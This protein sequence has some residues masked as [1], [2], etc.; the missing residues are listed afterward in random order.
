MPSADA[1]TPEPQGP[2]PGSFAADLLRAKKLTPT[3]V[4]VAYDPMTGLALN[5]S[6][7]PP[8][9][10]S[11]HDATIDK[12]AAEFGVDPSF[13]RAIIS[14]GERS[15]VRATS[16][17]GAQ[18]LMQLMPLIQKTY[19]VTDPMDPD[20]N[21]K[22]GVRHLRVLL[23]K[24]EGDETKTAAAYNAGEPAVNKA[25][26]IP[27]ITETQEYVGRVMQ[28]R[29]GP[30]LDRGSTPGQPAPLPQTP[31][32]RPIPS[33][34]APTAS[35]LRDETLRGAAD[36]VSDVVEAGMR[37]GSPLV[38]LGLATAPWATGIAMGLAT[39]ADAA[40]EEFGTRQGWSPE[41]VRLA[42]NAAVIA[43]LG[44]GAKRIAK[45]V[46]KG[47]SAME[48]SAWENGK[49]LGDIITKNAA[50]RDAA[51][52]KTIEQRT[53][54]DLNRPTGAPEP[55]QPP[56]PAQ[57]PVEPPAA[58]WPS[59]K[60]PA[61]PAPPGSF[62]ADL[63]R[64]REGLV[65]PPVSIARV[66]SLEVLNTDLTDAMNHYARQA[67][68]FEAGSAAKGTG[69]TY[70]LHR[71]LREA[72]GQKNWEDMTPLE[73][74][75]EFLE[76]A[77]KDVA[78]AAQEATSPISYLLDRALDPLD[79]MAQVYRALLRRA[80][81]TITASGGIKLPDQ[82]QKQLVAET[83]S[84]PAL[85]PPAV[86]PAVQPVP[87]AVAAPIPVEAV[88][89]VP[90]PIVAPAAPEP[91]V[92]PIPP[93]VS[94]TVEPVAAPSGEQ[95]P[96]PAKTGPSR[97]MAEGKWV[98]KRKVDSADIQTDAKTYQFRGGADEYGNIGTLD[99]VKEWDAIEGESRPVFLHETPTGL[100]VVDGHQRLSAAR[101]LRAEGKSVPP[102]EAL[103]F[104]AS[105]GWRVP[106][107]RRIASLTNIRQGTASA[108]DV[109]R[110]L[111][112]D[113]L[114]KAERASIPK[115]FNRGAAFRQGE[116]IAKLGEPAYDA[117]VAGIVPPEY[118][119]LVGQI[120]TDES[121]QMP[122][123][124]ALRKA[125]P[126]N[127]AQAEAMIRDLLNRRAAASTEQIDM[128]GQD[129]SFIPTM[130][131]RA[132]LVDLAGKELGSRKSAFSNL[133]LNAGRAEKAGNVLNAGENL[134]QKDLAATLR[135]LLQKYANAVGD[136]QKA[137]DYAATELVAGRIKPDEALQPIFDALETD[138]AAEFGGSANRS[139]GQPSGQSAGAD[140]PVVPPAPAVDLAPPPA[141]PE[142][143]PPAEKR[144]PPKP[145]LPSQ[146]EAA[147]TKRQED[148][149]DRI[150]AASEI[151]RY[152]PDKTSDKRK[153]ENAYA[154]LRTHAGRLGIEVPSV[155]TY[156][157]SA[158]YRAAFNAVEIEIA[159]QFGSHPTTAMR[160]KRDAAGPPPDSK[161]FATRRVPEVVDSTNPDREHLRSQLGHAADVDDATGELVASH[162]TGDASKTRAMLAGSS[163]LTAT[164]GADRQ[165]ELGPGFY[166]SD[167]PQIWMSRATSKWD[168][169][170]GL[171]ELQ[172]VEIG[173]K[174]E[175]EIDQ[176]R[177]TKY[178]T[179]SERDRAIR[180][181]RGFEKGTAA[182]VVLG[183]QPYNIAWW[184]P[185]WLKSVGVTPGTQPTSVEVRFR[186][187]FL[188]LTDQGYPS[189]EEVAAYRR[190]GYD[191]AYLRSGMGSTAQ[192]AIWNRDAITA[193]DGQP[194]ARP[195]LTQ[196]ALPGA[197][198]VRETNI[199]TPTFE[200]P[201]SLTANTA[202]GPTKAQVDARQDRLFVTK[203]TAR[204]QANLGT[205]DRAARGEVG[206]VAASGQ[207]AD[208]RGTR[209]PLPVRIAKG[210]PARHVEAAHAIAGAPHL[211]PEGT[212]VEANVQG[213]IFTS[214]LG[215][216][217]RGV[218]TP[219]ASMP[220]THAGNIESLAVEAADAGVTH[221]TAGGV[222]VP[223]PTTAAAFGKLSP[224]QVKALQGT[225][226]IGGYY[227][228]KTHT[229]IMSE[230]YALE[231][232]AWAE[233]YF[234]HGVSLLSTAEKT[235]QRL[236]TVADEEA[237][238][239]AGQRVGADVYERR[240]PPQDAGTRQAVRTKARYDPAELA[241]LD[242]ERW[243]YPQAVPSRLGAK[244][245]S[246]E[247]RSAARNF[248]VQ[249][250]LNRYAA[251]EP[252]PD[253]IRHEQARTLSLDDVNSLSELALSREREIGIA[254]KNY[255]YVQRIDEEREWRAAHPGM[256]RDSTAYDAYYENLTPKQRQAILAAL[257]PTTTVRH[258]VRIISTKDQSTVM[259][260][261][262]VGDAAASWPMKKGDSAQLVAHLA[263]TK[264][265][266]DEAREIGLTTWLK[267]H[268]KVTKDEV[269]Q[270]VKDH[271]IVLTET[272]LSETP[273]MDTSP[274]MA[275]I[276][277]HGYDVQTDGAD[278]DAPYLVDTAGEAVELTYTNAGQI[279]PSLTRVIPNVVEHAFNEM[280]DTYSVGN[281]PYYSGPHAKVKDYSAITGGT[282][283]R[284][285]LLHFPSTKQIVTRGK[286]RWTEVRQDV[287]VTG[288]FYRVTAGGEWDTHGYL[289]KEDAEAGLGP[290]TDQTSSVPSYE[291]PHY[292]APLNENLLL[293]MRVWDYELPGGKKILVAKE[294][295]SDIHH[296]GRKIGYENKQLQIQIDELIKQRD[297]V[298]AQI[299]ESQPGASLFTSPPV[300]LREQYNRIQ[301]QIVEMTGG[302]YFKAP[303]V[304]NFPFKG[305]EWE[306]LALKRL[307]A[308]AQ[309]QGYAGIG[310]TTGIQQVELYTEALRKVVDHITWQ[311]F[312]YAQDTY[313]AG[314]KDGRTVFD[315]T[316]GADGMFTDGPA[317]GKPLEEVLGKEVAAK[318]QGDVSG[319]LKG[320]NLTIGGEGLKAAYDKRLPALANELAKKTGQRVTT[321]DVTT[322]EAKPFPSTAK[323][324]YLPLKEVRQ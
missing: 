278:D 160:A 309:K 84:S 92:A 86:V 254:E 78:I 321:V 107:V 246:A 102:L 145:K 74:Q 300:E 72:E 225:F 25:G 130:K 91:V 171:D 204:D 156:F 223:I 76:Y 142:A 214:N 161:R 207:A 54:I 194:V 169:L 313:V 136:T 22:A 17:K 178:I 114:T 238:H 205:Q 243:P 24:Y 96:T 311:K 276:K 73:R 187:K 2:P 108:I 34:R 294:I 212:R 259:A 129:E 158:K 201:F 57:T 209:A 256:H 32:S 132:K 316:V 153:F 299:A 222:K 174:L 55:V 66:G 252:I 62:A 196:P 139:G 143:P 302:N 310:W 247:A 5:S 215:R 248:T 192:L 60:A 99:S 4:A 151:V 172:R 61:A 93:P 94:Q 290:Q 168:F 228:T 20:Q 180:D 45:G 98:S 51:I 236:T 26:G 306:T 128:F 50:A 163:D 184:K 199:P 87:E 218:I 235:A 117:V 312:G 219:Q 103:I 240:G 105:E 37:L 283:P 152:R 122:L 39:A 216:F 123:L 16:P 1:M 149:I 48:A 190:A 224:P 56:V 270:F 157:D 315:G 197:E 317:Q 154:T 221:F 296:T 14:K 127:A 210:A 144:Q 230:K 88:P 13:V 266:L 116:E 305:T 301:R 81:A 21:I 77:R 263:K 97:F 115:D 109:A 286:S 258:A 46:G 89:P 106:E 79:P 255:P 217:V 137:L 284:E 52:P 138:Y 195:S 200:V 101:R 49:R 239:R 15:G 23:D 58:P 297:A 170:E 293:H 308:L 6:P 231:P 181:I 64:S 118:A 33:L 193:V 31:Q 206:V 146:K 188:N 273:E 36:T 41:Y 165:A 28:G 126:E 162:V 70:G 191:G 3:P 182:A 295:Q 148:S 226:E 112:G 257:E 262:Y 175:K 150:F 261:D 304:P 211:F 11:P 38:I 69:K 42:R 135:L 29:G 249:Q 133:V 264:G 140:R 75:T 125:E 322:R 166:V 241:R 167:I 220:S 318:V 19:G 177:F 227:N 307:I 280:M 229:I 68:G 323:I 272:T 40:A 164:Y 208:V 303:G 8:A 119:R 35:E 275:I 59:P 121:A 173:R 244:P 179:E 131:A 43:T 18:G 268:P 183:G 155:G 65:V 267:T 202:K 147:A 27:D 281:R 269:V 113:P 30:P 95:A 288:R 285:I 134:K 242:R 185:E 298:D 320:D 203:E 292:D 80:G 120:V 289:R 279:Y 90:A 245:V 10:A 234:H 314:K 198:A 47:L 111:R 176:Q 291:A 53:I 85:S 319:D 124:E 186:G 189:A 282:N 7:A 12:Y 100:N 253:R 63:A 9:V 141:A 265:A 232:S 274:Q 44:V 277:Q 287:H 104:S 110:L 237:A 213:I 67:T 83:T 71:V 250:N 159:K 260:Y 251:D 82:L 233:E 271:E 324:H